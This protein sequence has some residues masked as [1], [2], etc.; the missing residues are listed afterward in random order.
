MNL[1][2]PLKE[3]FLDQMS[4]YEWLKKEPAPWNYISL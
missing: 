3:K 4:N 2:V 1:R